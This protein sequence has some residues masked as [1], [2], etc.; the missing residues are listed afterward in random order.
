M[1]NNQ[2]KQTPIK[3]I[4]IEDS[5][6]STKEV[7][8]N[9][10]KDEVINESSRCLNCKNPKCVLACPLHNNIPLINS[11]VSQN[12]FLEAREELDKTNPF[13]SICSRVCQQEKQCEGSCI[14]GNKV[15]NDPVAIGYIEKYLADNVLIKKKSKTK[16]D[17]KV[18]IIGSGPS[19]LACANLLSDYRFSV[20]IFEKEKYIGGILQDG[21]PEFVLPKKIL[22]KYIKN[23]KKKRVKI[24]LN[25]GLSNEHSLNYFF[26]ELKF[27]YVYLAIGYNTSRRMNIKNEFSKGVI[28]Y[29]EYL[30]YKKIKNKPNEIIDNAKNIVV[31][32]GGNTAIDCSRYAARGKDVKVINLYRRTEK[33]M[34]ANIKEYISAIN[35]NIE[36]NF[37]V[38]PIEVITDSNNKITAIK[39]IKMEL[40]EKDESGRRSPVPIENS[41]FK[42]DCDLLILAVGAKENSDL[43]TCLQEITTSD[44]GYVVVNEDLM[45]NR[46]RVFA[47]GDLIRG[48]STVVEAIRDGINVARKII[49]INKL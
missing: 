33:E 19:G 36:F 24:N 23:L 42:I 44:K 46:E 10:S 5:L 13:P 28:T 41:E 17:K 32:G 48:P 15:I 21:I 9:Y 35:E 38:N 8:L 30:N 25:K 22:D 29:K 49:K 4:S 11:L 45:T 2:N 34:P 12:K 40:G 20:E 27:D 14:R 16:I 37:L 26:D 31:V 47:G 6:K 39:C 18:A 43:K 7:I 1:I 3:K